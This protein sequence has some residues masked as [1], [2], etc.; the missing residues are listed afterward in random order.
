MAIKQINTYLSN[1]LENRYDSFLIVNKGEIL[2]NIILEY[3]ADEV[4]VLHFC[5]FKKNDVNW[6]KYYNE[7]FKPTLPNT[8]KHIVVAFHP[9]NKARIRLFESYGMK[10]EYEESHDL[11]VFHDSL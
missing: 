11:Y 10:F 5:V 1:D 3:F 4:G 9:S 2:A 6:F 7:T 8:V